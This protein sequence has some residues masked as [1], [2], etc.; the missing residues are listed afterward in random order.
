MSKWLCLAILGVAAFALSYVVFL[1]LQ[2]AD[3]PVDPPE[4]VWIPGGTFRRGSDNPTV[5]DASPIHQ[6]SVDGFWIDR[7]TVTNEQFAAFVRATG[8]VTVAERPLNP[9]DYPD[10]PAEELAPGGLVFTPTNGPVPLDKHLRWW[11]VI[12]GA[13]WRHPEGPQSDLKGREKHPVVQVAWEDAVAYAAWAGRRLPTEA[14]FEFAARGGLEGKKYVWGDELK[15]DGKW[16]ANIWQG[17]FPY[18]NTAEDGYVATAPVGSFPAN[19]YGLYD[20]A[21]N[22][23][24]W[25]SD[26]Y[27]YDYY[28]QLAAG[29][30]P[31]RNPRG[32]GSSFDPQEPGI[33]KRVTRGGSFLCTDQYCSAYEAGVR[34]KAAIDSGTNHIGFRCVKNGPRSSN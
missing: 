1:S 2:D 12:Q 34:G 6:V 27:R 10:A 19:G 28:R 24:Q 22:V 23:W 26:W 25:C 33:K 20:M 13:D 9:E 16:M 3:T 29:P 18:R 14:E 8:Y 4:Q 30:Q 32:P 15:P 7:T 5:H 31:V 21:G 11:R 17:A